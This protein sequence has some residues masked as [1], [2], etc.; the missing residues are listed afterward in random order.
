MNFRDTIRKH[1]ILSFVLLAYFLNWGGMAAQFAGILPAMGE[2][3]LKY[4]GHVIGVLRGRRTLLNWS[5]NLAAFFVAALTG[6]RREILA[7]LRRFFH[8]RIGIRI[9]LG[10]IFLPIGV[11]GVSVILC[12]LRGGTLN[13]TSWQELPWVFLLRNLFSLSTGGLGEEA[14]WRGF[15]LIQLQKRFS[16]LASSLMVGLLW[17]PIHAPMWWVRGWSATDILFFLCSVVCL[18][19]WLAWFYNRTGSL[20]IVAVVHNVFN[21]V[22]ATL[23][24]GFAAVMPAEK[25]MP[26]FTVTLF[27]FT[28]MLAALTRGRFN[29]KEKRFP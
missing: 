12:V 19:V 7:L 16:P 13:L 6:G 17:G 4:Q 11:A 26:Y 3:A 25:F 22:D 18:S 20:L 21:A 15:A 9:W 5:V 27:A 8:W 28:V 24:R 10:A 29:S 23:S 14:G 2:H 1:P